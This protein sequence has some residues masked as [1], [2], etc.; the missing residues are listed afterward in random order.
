MNEAA[1]YRVPDAEVHRAS[2]LRIPQ[3]VVSESSPMKNAQLRILSIAGSALRPG[4]IGVDLFAGGGGWSEG[5]QWATGVPPAIAVNHDEHS[6][7]M[8]T[9]NHPETEHHHEDVFHVDPLRATRGRPVGWLHGSPDCRH[10]SRAKGSVPN[11][12]RALSKKIRGLAWVIVRWAAAVRPRIISLENV[13]EFTT[14]GPLHQQGKNAG[15]PM[16]RRKGETFRK[17]VSAL[18]TLGY[19]VE[20]RELKACDFGAPT[21][22]KRL[23]LV[24]R[25]DGQVIR[26]PKPTHGPGRSKPYRTAAECIDWSIEVPSIFQC[27]CLPQIRSGRESRC[28]ACGGRIKPL[29]EATQRRI[30]EGIRRFILEN[31]RPFIV[32]LTHGGRLEDLDEPFRTLTA[33]HRGEKALIAPTLIQA[34]YG[35]R[36]GQKPRVLDLHQPL[37]TVVGGGRKHALVAAF[38]AKHYGGHTTPGSPLSAPIDTITAQDHHALVA[39][40][41]ESMY[42]NSKGAPVDDPIPTITAQSNHHGLVAATLAKYY[43]S[44]EHGQALTVPLHTIPTKDRFALVAAFLQR[45]IPGLTGDVVTVTVGDDIYAI[46]DIGMRMLVPR[47]L[48]RGN[49]FPDSYILTGTTTQQVARV[50]NSVPPH[51]A[52]AIVAANLDDGE[53]VERAA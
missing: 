14:W 38:L 28:R 3:S 51:F 12:S 1:V 49:G 26:W 37:G 17:F 40:H 4:E 27:T 19:A 46:A 25:C 29:A 6:I 7:R 9:A 45:F 10:F 52:K 42:S 31:E 23:F 2:P 5:F 22:R 11:T 33:A 50:G 16:K 36:D 39:C 30:A 20:W 44:D 41:L 24:A 35:E 34:G 13:S 53:T 18:E 43:G 47:E 8:H 32:N 21:S 48:A 15:A